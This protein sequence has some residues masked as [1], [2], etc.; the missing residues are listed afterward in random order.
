MS[1]TDNK[2][3]IVSA[4]S[5]GPSR[6]F[7]FQCGTFHL[8]D[9]RYITSGI[10]GMSDLLGWHTVQITSDMVGKWVPIYSTIEVKKIGARTAR[11]RLQ[12]QKSF[13]AEVKRH[14]GLSGFARTV[15]EARTILNQSP[16]VLVCPYDESES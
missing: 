10:P 3:D 6:L 8:S 11:T 12:L 9:G 14:G 5:S 1:E 13:I 16:G 7:K 15:E 4:L 2:N